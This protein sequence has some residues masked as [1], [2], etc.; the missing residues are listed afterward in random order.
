M[1][2]KNH[3]NPGRSRRGVLLLL[4]LSALTMFM[5]LGALML[6]LATRART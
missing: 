5:M 2:T 4:V 3:T 6:V 1:K